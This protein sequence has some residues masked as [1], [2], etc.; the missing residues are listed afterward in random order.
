MS[1][2]A[3]LT[4]LG[5]YSIDEKTIIIHPNDGF[6]LGLMT[7]EHV[8]RIHVGDA[9]DPDSLPESAFGY[10]K[11]QLKNEV[12]NGHV[13]MGIKRAEQLGGAKKAIVHFFKGERY[14][15]LLITPA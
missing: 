6:D 14:A 12:R 1:S 11:I 2:T 10:G 13:E 9:R 15:T 5:D 4:V 8:V 7:T 3:P